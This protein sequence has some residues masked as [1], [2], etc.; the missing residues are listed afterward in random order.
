MNNYFIK[1]GLL[2]DYK[3]ELLSWIDTPYY[4][5][6][7]KKGIGTDCLGFVGKSLLNVFNYDDLDLSKYTLPK[8]WNI[9]S[10]RDL[11]VKTLCVASKDLFPFIKI[12]IYKYG[13]VEL[14]EGDFL[15]MKLLKSKFCNHIGV[16]LDKR[17]NSYIHA[18]YYKAKV[19]VQSL[20][21]DKMENHIKYIVKCLDREE[22]NNSIGG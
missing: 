1:H 6:Q 11:L 14:E 19:V 3:K 12:K 17:D 16:Y 2:D 13:E 8:Q 18:S 4:S 20:K 9:H 15:M 21:E 7:H 5:F 22:Y 10:T